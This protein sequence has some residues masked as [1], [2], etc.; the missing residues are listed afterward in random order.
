LITTRFSEGSLGDSLKL[1]DSS[2]AAVFF[3]IAELEPVSS[4]PMLLQQIGN[5]D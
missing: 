1:G 3:V 4:H 5:V 2:N